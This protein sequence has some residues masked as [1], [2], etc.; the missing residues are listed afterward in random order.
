MQSY[1]QI[2]PILRQ[3]E[4]VRGLFVVAHGS[5]EITGINSDGQTVLIHLARQGE[6]FGDVEALSDEPTAANCTAMSNTVLLFYPKNLLLNAMRLPIF[7]RNIFALTYDRLVRDNRVKFVDQFYPVDQRL[8]DYLH[9]LS[10]DRLEISKTQAEL[11]N[12]LGCARQTLNRELG[13]LRDQGIIEMKKGKI[14]VTNRDALYA[15]ATKGDAIY[16]IRYTGT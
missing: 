13:L 10:V 8:C 5:V 11:A 4:A 12:L 14:R 6:V 9:R 16:Q 3:G 1:D 2:T 7:M 15:E